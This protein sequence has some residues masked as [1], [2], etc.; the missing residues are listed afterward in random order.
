M[1]FLEILMCFL[2]EIMPENPISW[3][4]LC[5]FLC[6][7]YKS[8]KDNIASGKKKKCLTKLCFPKSNFFLQYFE[9]ISQNFPGDQY[10]CYFLKEQTNEKFQEKIERLKKCSLIHIEIADKKNL[11]CNIRNDRIF[12]RKNWKR[13]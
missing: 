5:S 8:C 4:F 12:A 7:L 13:S 1:M 9:A 6:V 3:I 2:G 11:L 10:F